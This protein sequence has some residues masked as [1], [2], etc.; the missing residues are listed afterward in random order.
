MVES[1]LWDT[2]TDR[3]RPPDSEYTHRRSA[4]IERAG[5]PEKLQKV[6]ACK[7]RRVGWNKSTAFETSRYTRGQG[8]VYLGLLWLFELLYLLERNPHFLGL[9]VP[10]LQK[11]TM[12][13]GSRPPF[14]S[15]RRKPLGMKEDWQTLVV[16]QASTRL[17]KKLPPE[18]LRS[19][20]SASTVLRSCLVAEGVATVS[21]DLLYDFAEIFPMSR[22]IECV[23]RARRWACRYRRR[24]RF[25]GRGVFL[26][27]FASGPLGVASLVGCDSFCASISLAA[28]IE[29]FGEAV[30]YVR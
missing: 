26:A 18:P 3:V 19:P 1:D 4:Y 25:A 22:L 29:R 6:T 12:R 13:M 27:S 16:F 7:I 24:G 17:Q 9:Q 5:T 21:L 30:R 20:P 28:L 23:T 15:L 11:Q 10:L 14:P 2:S 8:L